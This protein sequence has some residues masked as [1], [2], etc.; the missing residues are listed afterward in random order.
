VTRRSLAPQLPSG[1]VPPA[2]RPHE[3]PTPLPR[4]PGPLGL[5]GGP[6]TGGGDAGHPATRPHLTVVPDGIAQGRADLQFTHH[7][8]HGAS[9]GDPDL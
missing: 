5:Y 9:E 7:A 2:Q 3:A 4:D 8:G 6:L 1:T